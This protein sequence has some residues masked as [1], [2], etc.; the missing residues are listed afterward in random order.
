MIAAAGAILL[1]IGV[2]APALAEDDGTVG[3][4]VRVWQDAHNARRLYI[5]ARPANGSWRTLGT[6]RLTVDEGGGEGRERYHSVTVV[7]PVPGGDRG[8]TAE[9]EVRIERETAGGSFFASARGEG[10]FW[11]EAEEAFSLSEVTAN[12]W[13]RYGEVRLQAAISAPSQRRLDLKRYMLELINAAR[14]GAGVDRVTLGSNDAAQLHAE[15]SLSGCYSSHW[16]SDG[17]K[18]YMR[19]SLTGGYQSNAENGLGLDFCITAADFVR[20]LSSIRQEIRDAVDTFVESAPHRGNVL[21]AR[22]KAVTIGLAWDRYNIRVVQQFEGGYV[23]YEQLPSI[24][25]GQVELSGSVGQGARFSEAHDL[26]VQVRY[27]PPPHDLTLGQVTRTYCYGNGLPVAGLRRPLPAN[28]FYLSDEFTRTDRPC[29]D[30]YAVEP[31]APA[32]RSPSEANTFW[33]SARAGSEE[34][35]EVSVTV[36]WITAEAWMASEHAFSVRADLSEVLARH[37]PGVYTILVWGPIE[38]ELATISQYSIF[39]EAEPP[40]GYLEHR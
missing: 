30:P 33:E 35:L 32:P 16:G 19:Y 37:G 34:R 22:H 17:L 36:P 27:D 24:E 25:N 26:R 6:V 39:H 14:T 10:H 9:V 18:P 21:S 23:E 5:S 15:A 29:P 3:V 28:R 8:A 31:E 12:G 2:W 38:G 13:F 20:P 40:E 7:A 4:Q 11:S 1:A